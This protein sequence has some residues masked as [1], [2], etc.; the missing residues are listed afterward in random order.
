MGNP[1]MYRRLNIVDT[2][3]VYM[4]SPYVELEDVTVI[5][6]SE[7]LRFLVVIPVSVLESTSLTPDCTKY[8][9]LKIDTPDV[10]R[11]SSWNKFPTA[12]ASDLIS[13]KNRQQ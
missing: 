3:P 5:E 2:S 10:V 6:L 7:L 9:T 13:A 11:Y 8:D 4:K 12:N 1:T